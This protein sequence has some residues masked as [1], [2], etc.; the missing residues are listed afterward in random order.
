MNDLCR[1]EFCSEFC[2]KTALQIAEHMKLKSETMHVVISQM[3]ACSYPDDHLVT[4]IELLK[5]APFF[6]NNGVQ[7][8]LADWISL[9]LSTGLVLSD[10]LS[11]PN[12]LQAT[13]T[14]DNAPF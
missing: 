12:L 8:L 2:E 4:L 11:A 14:A 6:D 9:F 3:H 10:R 7:V 5:E 1:S 13:M